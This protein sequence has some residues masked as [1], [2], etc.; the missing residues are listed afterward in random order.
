MKGAFDQLVVKAFRG[1]DAA[2]LS[3]APVDALHGV[4]PEDAQRLRAAFGIE[5]IGDLAGSR[6]WPQR[7]QSPRRQPVA[8]TIPGPTHSGRHSSQTRP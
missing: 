5:T 1:Q 3:E 2:T 7:R 8:P 4:S 6:S